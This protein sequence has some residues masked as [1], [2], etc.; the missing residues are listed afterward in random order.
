MSSTMSCLWDRTKNCDDLRFF[1]FGNV[2]FVKSVALIV[3][4]L[5]YMGCLKKTCNFWKN[6]CNRHVSQ[7][8]ECVIILLSI[9]VQSQAL[10]RVCDP[11]NLVYIPSFFPVAG[12]VSRT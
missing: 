3:I 8:F 5:V 11:T 9:Y 6:D 10:S 12:F 7:I 4:S 2:A 1:L